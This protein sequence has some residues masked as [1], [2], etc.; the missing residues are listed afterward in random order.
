MPSSL[1]ICCEKRA[2]Y[3]VFLTVVIVGSVSSWS[4]RRPTHR[5]ALCHASELREIVNVCAPLRTCTNRATARR[6]QY[7]TIHGIF[8]DAQH[9]TVCVLVKSLHR[10]CLPVGDTVVVVTVLVDGPLSSLQS[11]NDV[12]S[13]L[14]HVEEFNIST[15][16][17]GR[18]HHESCSPRDG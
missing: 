16:T 14:H 3:P 1:E 11:P 4:Q 8:F 5:L 15:G 17:D 6:A 2:S 12:V 9:P 10:C 13:V 18:S 7:P